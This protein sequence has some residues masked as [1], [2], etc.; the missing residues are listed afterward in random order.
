MNV[1]I[2]PVIRYFPGIGAAVGIKHVTML[3]VTSTLLIQTNPATLLD[4]ACSGICACDTARSDCS[5]SGVTGVGVTLRGFAAL[6]WPSGRAELGGRGPVPA[7]A[8]MQTLN[9]NQ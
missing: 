4:S 5:S 9:S 8:V 1:L 3:F 6:T 7:A 2:V